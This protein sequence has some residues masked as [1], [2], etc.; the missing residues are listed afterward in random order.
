MILP[1]LYA[2]FGAE[3]GYTGV[4][5]LLTGVFLAV[6]LVVGIFGRETKGKALQGH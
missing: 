5:I 3:N 2:F 1:V 4:F 6:A